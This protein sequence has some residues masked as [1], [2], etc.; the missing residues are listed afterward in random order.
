VPGV[1]EKK[2]PMREIAEKRGSRPHD[3]LRG[4]KPSPGREK[5]SGTARKFSSKHH[6]GER[7]K[8]P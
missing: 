7:K 2:G 1:R 3:I 8:L 6:G 4:K 5:R